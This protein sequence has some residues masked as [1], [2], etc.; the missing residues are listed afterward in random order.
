MNCCV[1]LLSNAL[2]LQKS[3]SCTGIIGLK[4]RAPP[5]RGIIRN[6]TATQ[7]GT[8]F[9]H[10]SGFGKCG[11][12]VIRVSGEKTKQAMSA[13]TKKKKLPNAK[14]VFVSRLWHPKSNTMLDRAVVFWFAA[15]SSFTGEDMCEFQVHG[16]PA[17]IAS[18]LDALSSIEGL[19]PAEAG[20]FTKRAFL[21][22]KLD[23]TEVEG[24]G[25]LIH[26][27]TEGQRR[28]AV[29]QMEGSLSSLYQTWTKQILKS[30]AHCEAFI[31]FGEDQHLGDQV[32]TNVVTEVKDVQLK[33]E[34]HLQDSHRGERL[35]NGVRVCIAGLPNV[36]KSTLLN[37]ITQ[38]QAAIVSPIAGT[39]R[40]VIET[41]LDIDGFP[42]LMSDTAGLRQSEDIIEKEGVSRAFKKIKEADL[43]VFLLCADS[44][45][46]SSKDVGQLIEKQAKELG[47]LKDFNGKQLL[48]VVNKIDLNMDTA[49]EN[50]DNTFYV[51]CKNMDGMSSFLKHF[52]TCVKD[53]CGAASIGSIPSITQ[54]RHRKHLADCAQFLQ[55][56]IDNF[57]L[58]IV[59]A[60]EYMRMALHELGKISGKVD[61]E[62]ILDVIF[63]DFCIGK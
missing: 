56:A 36:G 49:Q 25:D 59:I 8:I 9:A 1:R 57:D 13:I 60:A 39:T 6:Y 5:Y 23:L 58:D 2:T 53:L 54:Q 38:R 34:T 32:L 51:S 35:R 14:R 16:G 42:V 48:Y 30:M 43:I 26:A 7:L 29:H 21:N 19:R 27:E 12:A 62:Q 15:P 40:D 10:S 63:Q 18:V 24:L 28:Q 44:L 41:A 17:V 31:D 11:V 45:K 61:A 3:C 47:L 50:S 37:L 22:D 52:S 55:Q 33:I 20:D 46:S 4:K